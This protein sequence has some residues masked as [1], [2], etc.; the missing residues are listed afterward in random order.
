MKKLL[1]LFVIYL[2]ID[3]VF[4]QQTLPIP[5]SIKQAYDKSTRNNTGEPGSR[6]WQNAADY[7]IK[8]KFDPLTRQV[9]GV[10]DLVYFNH[11]P[12]TL[13]QVWFKLYPNLYKKGVARN[14]KIAEADLGAGVKVLTFQENGKQKDLNELEVEGTNM[15]TQIKALAPGKSIRFNIKYSYLLNEASPVRTGQ[16]DEGAFFLAYFFPRIAVYD[17]IDG[18]N[19]LPYLGREEFYNDFCNFK[20]DVEVPKNFIIWATGDLQNSK[21]VLKKKFIRRLK[22]AER[23][24]LVINVIDSSDLK[25]QIITNQKAFN[26]WKFEAKN[27]TDFSFATSNHY[28]WL[29]SSLRVDSVTNR[30]TRIDAVFNHKHKEYK[31]WIDFTRKTVQHMSFVFPKLPFPYSHETLFDGLDEMEYPMMANANW[32]KDRSYAIGLVDHEVFHSIFPFYVGVNESKYA[33]MDEGWAAMGEWIISST[34]DPAVIDNFGINEYGAYSGNEK[35]QP[36]ITQSNLLDNAGYSFNSYTKSGLAYLY[37]REYLGN[38]VFIEALQHYVNQ[39]KGKHPTPFDFYNSMNKGAG[40]NLN[41]VWKRWFFDD[42]SVDMALKAVVKGREGYTVQI[43][44]KGGRP[45]PV[46]LTFKYVD[47]S[48]EKLHRSFGVWEKGE[49]LIEIKLNTAKTLKVVEMDN[50]YVPDKNKKDNIIIVK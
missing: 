41:W 37:L 29:S 34:I 2:S 15:H 19:K 50:V 3:H 24:D 7:D 8:I 45:L 49:K 39:W 47:G 14:T 16:V 17:D 4:A 31:E 6:Y 35:E 25:T 36:I 5:A 27:V 21:R 48:A 32:V 46:Y 1:L 40:K 30:R 38:K 44:N 18:W 33:W 10:V 13:K 20:V 42:G 12:D 9:N 11:S 28:V 43:E 26:T 23:S 22:E